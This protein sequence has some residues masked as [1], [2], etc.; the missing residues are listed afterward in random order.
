MMLS[1]QNESTDA[2]KT[3][4]KRKM[5]PIKLKVGVTNLKALRNG[6]LI[7]ESNSKEDIEILKNE[8]DKECSQ[9]LEVN[10]P[11]LRN[12]FVIVYNISKNFYR[13]R[14]ASK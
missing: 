8:I 12:P 6:K 3:L 7:L 9:I 14:N 10:V 13:N 5:N 1:K 4:L 2:M 11:K